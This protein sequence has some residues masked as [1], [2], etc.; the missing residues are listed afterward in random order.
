M[1]SV[2]VN[3][4]QTS[5]KF[6]TKMWGNWFEDEINWHLKLLIYI[7]SKH[8]HKHTHTQTQTYIHTQAHRNTNN[9]YG[10]SR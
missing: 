5:P 9:I 10:I 2:N 6:N 1:N 8:T 3:Q 4:I 7:H